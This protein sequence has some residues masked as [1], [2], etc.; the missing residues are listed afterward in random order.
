[1]KCVVQ[2][3]ASDEYCLRERLTVSIFEIE[4]EIEIDKGC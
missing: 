2:R 3:C 1:M 4:I